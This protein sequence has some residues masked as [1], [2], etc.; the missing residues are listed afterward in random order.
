[1]YVT[2]PLGYLWKRANISPSRLQRV[3]EVDHSFQEL[4]LTSECIRLGVLKRLLLEYAITM[5]EERFL[6]LVCL[7]LS[8]SSS[9]PL[10]AESY[11]QLSRMQGNYCQNGAILKLIVC[12]TCMSPWLISV[13]ISTRKL[14]RFDWRRPYH[15]VQV[16]LF[17]SKAL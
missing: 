15:S 8:P 16:M 6:A 12:L 17:P 14:I 2:I 9:L 4:L 13:V 1:M 3:A 11:L 7:R 10:S 5:S